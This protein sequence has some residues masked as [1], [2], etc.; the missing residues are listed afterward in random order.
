MNNFE[1]NNKIRQLRKLIDNNGEKIKP[2]KRVTAGTSTSDNAYGSFGISQITRIYDI[3]EYDEEG[4][5]K[6]EFRF[7]YSPMDSRFEVK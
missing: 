4:N 6:K 7:G 5:M 3:I 1:I 2:V